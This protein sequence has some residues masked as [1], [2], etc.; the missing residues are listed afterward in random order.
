MSIST[1]LK[2]TFCSES[3]ATSNSYSPWVLTIVHIRGGGEKPCDFEKFIMVV[4]FD[5]VSLHE[6]W[7]SAI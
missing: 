2:V 4:E 6:V 1:K 3:V 5:G 7:L